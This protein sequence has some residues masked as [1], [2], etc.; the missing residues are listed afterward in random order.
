MA[1]FVSQVLTFLI[2]TT[3]DEFVGE[4][5]LRNS[6]GLLGDLAQTYGTA[7]KDQ[8]LQ[9]GVSRMLTMGKS[10]A[11]KSTVNAA[12]YARKVSQKLTKLHGYF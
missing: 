4:G 6:L 1:P 9:Q 3:G 8:L 7:I 5:Y 2:T 10:R 12:K 11:A